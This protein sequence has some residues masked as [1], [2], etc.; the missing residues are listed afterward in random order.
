M[1]T[2]KQA[3]KAG[4]HVSPAGKRL[5]VKVTHGQ[6]ITTGTILVRQRGT[7]MKAGNNVKIGRDH[8]LFS[9]VNGVVSFG[10]KFGKKVVSVLTK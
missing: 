6:N 7:T 4:Q 5:G 9:V 10:E 3:G 2:H 8:S 1:S